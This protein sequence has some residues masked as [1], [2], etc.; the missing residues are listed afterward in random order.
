MILNDLR[1]NLIRN[2]DIKQ[3]WWGEV[4]MTSHSDVRLQNYD[5]FLSLYH[6]YLQYHDTNTIPT[7]YTTFTMFLINIQPS[8]VR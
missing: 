4:M 2:D 7:L 5:C 1:L 8:S 3:K 6:G